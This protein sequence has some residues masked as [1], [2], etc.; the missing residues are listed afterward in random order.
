MEVLKGYN[1][2]KITFLFFAL[3]ITCNANCNPLMHIGIRL[4]LPW[5]N[6]FLARTS[7]YVLHIYS[8]PKIIGHI[9]IYTSRIYG[10]PKVIRFS[11]RGIGPID[12]KGLQYIFLSSSETIGTS[13]KR[14][15]NVSCSFPRLFSYIF[16]LPKNIYG[17][18]DFSC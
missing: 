18:E 2:L 9:C 8:V 11:F 5:M 14:C 4:I 15:A 13:S 17:L 16:N 12:N 7:F 6:C 3:N 10:R 1:M